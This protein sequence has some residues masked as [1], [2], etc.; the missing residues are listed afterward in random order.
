MKIIKQSLIVVIAMFSIL[1]VFN[2]KAN[3][4]AANKYYSEYP[5]YL[6][7]TWHN[8]YFK[9][10]IH[11][12]TFEEYYH[13]Q[14]ISTEVL[15]KYHKHSLTNYSDKQ[16]EKAKYW[17]YAFSNHRT[18]K[19]G[20]IISSWFAGAKPTIIKRINGQK[21]KTYSLMAGS[22]ASYLYK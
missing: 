11:K 2:N 5:S 22:K 7:G 8:K 12:K 15:K 16:L 4:K 18:G 6:R 10:K 13:N 21:L 19:K 3:V 17:S 1:C 9:W 20:I 14:N